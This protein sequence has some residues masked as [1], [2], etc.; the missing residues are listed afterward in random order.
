MA[1]TAMAPPKMYRN[2]TKIRPSYCFIRSI[3]SVRLAPVILQEASGGAVTGSWHSG[4]PQVEDAAG[5][6]GP[7]E[8]GKGQ[9]D[10]SG[11]RG[12][13]DRRRDLDGSASYYDPGTANGSDA[14]HRRRAA[15]RR[16]PGAPRPAVA[17]NGAASRPLERVR[18]MNAALEAGVAG[19]GEMAPARQPARPRQMLLAVLLAAA[20]LVAGVL[21]YRSLAAG[22]TS[23]RGEGVP[24]PAYA[25]T[26]RRGGAD[27]NR[28]STPPNP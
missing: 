3:R 14:A 26:F 5:R 20:G 7:R 25:P 9:V 24:T 21:T 28:K 8:A 23:F 6:P 27:Q 22:P 4:D 2:I 10:G 1:G 12:S 13:S 18:G 16:A 19:V 15:P 17:H 11:W